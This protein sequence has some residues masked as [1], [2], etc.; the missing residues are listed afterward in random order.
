MAINQKKMTNKIETI[1]SAGSW[2]SEKFN[3]T[4]YRFNLTLDNGEV[5]QINSLKDECPKAQ[6]E[7]I[8]YNITKP[9]ND[10]FPAQ[11][12]LI[13]ENN[14]RGGGQGG[15]N[16]KN[17]EQIA[18]SVALKASVELAA[19]GKLDPKLIITS[20]NKFTRWLMTG[21]E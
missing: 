15:G 9:G 11:A 5:I 19:A 3:K 17:E 12:K 8:H 2:H 1:K 4:Y 18:R 6:G 21:Q 13:Q 7:T 16:P 14:F 10:Q 20:S